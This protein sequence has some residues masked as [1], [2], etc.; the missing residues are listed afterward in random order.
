VE[1]EV[2]A[3]DYYQLG[4]ELGEIV[5]QFD[6]IP[7]A[8]HAVFMKPGSVSDAAVEGIVLG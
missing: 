7:I 1:R 2:L 6:R 8:D 3:A 5:R 4:P